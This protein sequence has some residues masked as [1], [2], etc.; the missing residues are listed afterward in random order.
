MRGRNAH[1]KWAGT[2][3]AFIGFYFAVL[4]LLSDVLTH[5]HWVHSELHATIETLGGVTAVLIA[6]TLFQKSQKGQD[7]MLA[8]VATGFVSMGILDTAHAMSRPGD[9]FIFLH[10]VASLCG[11]FFFALA[12]FSDRS[13]M[14]KVSEFQWLFY[15]A[16]VLSISVGL[17]ALIYPGD[18]P[19]I[20]PL[21]NGQFTLAATLINTTAS[22]LFGVSAV[23]FYMVY[24][25][26]GDRK[27]LVFMCLALLFALSEMIFQF[28]KPWNGIWWAWHLVRFGAFM[29]TLFIV[30]QQHENSDT[31]IR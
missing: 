12:W 21:Y 31:Y 13:W 25:G 14:K 3:V 20:M 11:G 17:R 6:L 7:Q 22:L 18:V 19:K 27:Y 4:L 8:V 9:A 16:V 15:G 29:V 1:K 23:K 30:F 10:S 28:S 26:R 2:I 5:W 24:D